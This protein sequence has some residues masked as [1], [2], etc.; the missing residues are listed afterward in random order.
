M[1]RRLAEQPW[2]WVLG[3][4]LVVLALLQVSGRLEARIEP[5]TPLYQSMPLDSLE[6][7]LSQVRT[8]GYPLFLRAVRAAT[9][10]DRAAPYFHFL[11][12]LLAVLLFGR[13]LRTAEFSPGARGAACCVLLWSHAVFEFTGPLLTDALGVAAA[14]VAMSALIF[15]LLHASSVIAW[16]GLTLAIFA[17]YQVRPVYQFLAPLTPCLGLGLA[18]FVFRLPLDWR[19]GLRLFALLAIAAMGPL[20]AFCVFRWSVVGHFGLVS[21]DG[22]NW[23]GVAGQ[24]LDEDLLPALSPEVRPLAREILQRRAVYPEWAPPVNYWAMERNYNSLLY[25]VTVP[26]ASDVYGGDLVQMNDRMTALAMEVIALRPREYLRWLAW[27]GRD[28]LRSVLILFITDK[29]TRLC[30]LALLLMQA[31]VLLRHRKTDRLP[32]PWPPSE[33]R[34]REVNTLLWLAIGYGAPKLLLV[35]AVQVPNHRY[36][37]AAMI[38]APP[39][40]AVLTWHR[41]VQVREF[42]RAAGR[43]ADS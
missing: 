43:P 11:V 6:A 38:F 13:A 8:V 39:V 16:M 23:I 7:A 40:A 27:S 24:L 18:V 26:A 36:L 3:N 9:G 4:A 21:F 1:M 17:A 32:A 25:Q 12:Y 14:I 10:T 35:M 2:V 34:F 20:L 41:W 28:G 33:Q 42:L 5:D 15:T 19:K 31:A 30:L 37:S 29:G 22:Y